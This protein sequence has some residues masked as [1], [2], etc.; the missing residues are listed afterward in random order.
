[1]FFLCFFYFF[2]FDVDIVKFLL[3]FG[4]DWTK[5]FI[6]WGSKFQFCITEEINIEIMQKDHNEARHSLSLFFSLFSLSL[7]LFSHFLL[8]FIC[9]SYR[10]SLWD[11]T[12]N[13]LSWCPSRVFYRDETI[14]FY[15]LREMS[16][17]WLGWGDENGYWWCSIIQPHTGVGGCH[18][19]SSLICVYNRS[20]FF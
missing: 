7:S 10:L 15:I 12:N 2:S 3:P 5:R 11:D 6:L 17:T 18:F 13:L 14:Y 4:M 1:M 19:F 16:C 20:C 8:G 9:L